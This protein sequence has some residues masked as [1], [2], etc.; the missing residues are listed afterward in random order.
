MGLI[1]QNALTSRAKGVF[2]KKTILFS[3]CFALAST[4]LIYSASLIMPASDIFV[5]ITVANQTDYTISIAPMMDN[6]V[7]TVISPKQMANIKISRYDRAT[8]VLAPL[9]IVVMTSN[10]NYGPYRV[11]SPGIFTSN[12]YII[13]S[14]NLENGFSA[15]ALDGV[16]RTM[17]GDQFDPQRMRN[18]PL[19]VETE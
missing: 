18:M 12:D 5:P 6:E 19:R 2:M 13:F 11:Y 16:H 4:S 10:G 7:Q 1:T 17:R 9:N 3:L 8:P 14:G 15:G